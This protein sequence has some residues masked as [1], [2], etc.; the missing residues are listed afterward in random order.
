M[1]PPLSNWDLV[2]LYSLVI[3]WAGCF[4]LL[5]ANPTLILI[6]RRG[7][8]S[9]KWNLAMWAA[10]AM[11][12]YVVCAGGLVD[13]PQSLR[14]P[15]ILGAPAMAWTHFAYLIRRRWSHRHAAERVQVQAEALPVIRES[16]TLPAKSQVDLA[17]ADEKLAHLVTKH[18]NER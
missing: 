14:G 16:S 18:I 1:H 8:M 2:L 15:M 11:L 3:A 5:L 13:I 7:V 9:I 12:A 6:G 4:V 17:A 10:Y